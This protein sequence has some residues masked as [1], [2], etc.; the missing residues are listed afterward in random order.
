M[1]A[2]CVSPTGD[3]ACIPGMCPDWELN[4]QPFG[5]LAGAQSTEP[6]QPELSFNSCLSSD[7]LAYLLQMLL[8]AVIEVNFLVYKYGNI[9]PVLKT[10]L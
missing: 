7:L 4:R 1:I 9:I 2:S 10:I 6:H 5:S 3:L 8:Y